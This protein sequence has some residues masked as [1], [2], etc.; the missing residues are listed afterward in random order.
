MSAPEKASYSADGLV[1]LPPFLTEEYSGR[2]ST[3]KA[4]IMEILAADIGDATSKSP[5]LIVGRPYRAL[6]NITDM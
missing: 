4:T 2:R 3:A 5:H 1:F 6:L